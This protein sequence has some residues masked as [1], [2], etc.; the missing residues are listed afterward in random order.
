MAG[1]IEEGFGVVDAVPSP[2][3]RAAANLVANFLPIRFIGPAVFQAGT[4]PFESKEQLASQQ[5]ELRGTHVVHRDGDRVICVPVT[6]DTAEVGEQEKFSAR[7]HRSL[8]MRL[9][10]EV[11]VGEILAMGYKLRKFTQPT[12]VSR[13]AVQDLVA[14][15]A[16]SHREHLSAVH[17]YPEYRLSTRASGPSERPGVI[18][19]LKTRHEVDL[20][21][22]DLLRHGVSVEGRYVLAESGAVPVNGDL[23]E[24][25]YRR[26]VGA[27]ASVRGDRLLLRD[28]PGATEVHADQAW[29]EGRRETFEEVIAALTG[30]HHA[31]ILERLA[32]AAFV[33]L[34]GAKA[35]LERITALARRLGRSGPL[36]I[37]N[38]V[39]VEIGSPIGSPPAGGGN[40]PRV[41][42]TVIR[43]PTFVFDPG[44]DKTHRYAQSGLTEF[45]PFDSEFFTPQSPRILV[46][47]PRAY[48]GDVEIFIDRFRR[49]V[50]NSRVYAQGFVRKYR[51]T[52]CDVILEAFDAGPQDAAAYRSAC[53]AALKT[54]DKPHLAMVVTSEV[55]EHLQGDESPYLVA[56]SALMGQGVPVQDV[57]IETIRNGDLAD[58]LDTMALA[59][60]AKLGGRPFVIAAPRTIKQELVIGIGS[61]HVTPSR[62][63]DPERVVGITSVFSADG[64]YIL[65]TT[66]REAGYDQYSQELLRA[67]RVCIDE[68]KRRNAWQPQ[69]ALRLVFHVFKPLK[70]I[71]AEA[72]KHLVEGLLSE[73]RS[74][75][76]AFVH[77]SDE[78]D[79]TLFDTN[80]TG[81]G[82]RSGPGRRQP[83][84][85]F[86]PA[87]GHAVKISS[88]EM[89]LT[90]TGPRDMTLPTQGVPR[91][92]LL[93]L[94][95]ASTFT[96]IDYLTGQAFRF[97]AMNWRR[98]YPSSKPVTILYSDLIAS[99]LGQ[100]RHVRNW[101]ADIVAT[102]LTTSRWFL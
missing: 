98:F 42:S 5:E 91:P 7:E 29:L 95:R 16:G 92:L 21:V 63:S 90:V 77:V 41:A 102:E 11:L 10:R 80:S 8:A 69:G 94:H 55:Q 30:G 87:R 66:S 17:V 39:S 57:Q 45:G 47:T 68:V 89:L 35:R 12:F 36:T 59:C 99:L 75:E 24:H 79:W 20:T 40:A 23:D 15:C 74:V 96:D 25:V 33:E 27:V 13:Y 65:S 56:K 93:K 100:L 31:P 61:A 86:V 3:R 9:V 44:G 72:V 73:F 81:V 58:P 2:S 6:A 67:L 19:R 51:L 49:G 84:G 43:E 64:N 78:H 28:A 82:N 83:K 50:P 76:F 37:A 32:E 71:E 18:V 70:D 88:T 54:H 46:L 60:Y 38:G 85:Q 1:L 52:D 53:L 48:Q 34:T 4:M 22:A 101:N 62:L 14:Q 26:L 97:T